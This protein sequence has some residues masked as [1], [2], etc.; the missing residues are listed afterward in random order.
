MTP[1]NV[2]LGWGT[3]EANAVCLSTK[4]GK[5]YPKYVCICICVVTGVPSQVKDEVR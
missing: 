3:F 4:V 5:M 2:E 1:W